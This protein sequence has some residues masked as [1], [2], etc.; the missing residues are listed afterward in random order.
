MYTR[1]L[2]PLDGSITAEQVIPY[3]R[4]FARGLRLPVELLTVV[5]VTPLLTSAERARQFD[6]L[7]EEESRKNNAYLE[8][9]ANRFPES[10]VNRTVEQ[11][12]A[13]E[14]IIQKA[15]ADPSTVIAMTTHG[16]SGIQRW[17]LGS[18]AE[19]VLRA[20]TNPLLLVRAVPDGSVEGEAALKS[21]VVPL[22]GSELAEHVLPL[23]TEIAG[24]LKMEIVLLRAYTN[25]YSAFTGSSGK[26]A[27]N[28]DELLASVR[29]ESRNYLKRKMT[30]LKRQGIEQISYAIEEGLAADTIVSVANRTPRSLVVMCSH[31]RSGVRRWVLG[32]VAEIVV[33][34]SSYPVLV[35]RGR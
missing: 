13:A 27:V 23:V 33:R 35:M 24:K 21:V 28:I 17:L 4:V 34:H 18:V 1:M 3:A 19:K 15:A 26:Y 31:G 22:D 12:S 6:E 16:R 5:D 14:A 29:D 2:I 20:T 8:G 25:P 10:R 9:I 30:Q 7:A 32:S 11:G